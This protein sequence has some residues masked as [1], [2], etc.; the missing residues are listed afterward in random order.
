MCKMLLKHGFTVRWQIMLGEHA[1][2]VRSLLTQTHQR[3]TRHT[4]SIEVGPI[5]HQAVEEPRVLR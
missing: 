1:K 2:S 4:I 5:E 3:P